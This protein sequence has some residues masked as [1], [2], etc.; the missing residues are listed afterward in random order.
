M[1]VLVFCFALLLTSFAVAVADE[2]PRRGIMG[3][4]VGKSAD[5]GVIVKAPGAN[6]SAQ[7]QLQTGDRIV[8]VNG[9]KTTTWDEFFASIQG[10]K[11]GQVVKLGLSRAGNDASA[12]ITTI[13]APVPQLDG[14]PV[15]LSHVT[16]RDGSRVRTLLGAAKGDALRRNG[17]VPAVAILPGIPCQSSETLGNADH[18]YTKLFS[19]LTQA[20]FTVLLPEKPGIGDSEGT[21]C[22]DGGFDVEVEAFTLATKAL[23]RDSGVDA[24]RVYAI[25]LSLGGIQAPLVAREVKLAG[26]VTW[27]TVVMPWGDYLLTNFRARDYLVPGDYAK[28]DRNMR[29]WRRV[30]GDLIVNN[31]SPAQIRAS[32]PQDAALVEKEIDKLDH[33]AGRSIKF[34][35]ECD[36]APTAEAWGAFKGR[37]LALQGEYDWVSDAQDHSFAAK[38]VNNTAPGHATFEVIPGNDHAHSRH[39]NVAESFTKFGAGEKDDTSFNRMVAWLVERAKA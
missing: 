1:R 33:F 17:R 12:A 35:R 8:S 27:G 21:P 13:A 14:V 39:P 9:K 18:P 29:A 34:H 2:L 28:T 7:S 3:I 5:G 15:T 11:Q 26:I 37:L 24:E 30:L 10:L 19:K 16:L 6:P 36:R 20:G 31:K 38:I 4:P 23:A 32:R 22:I 25:G